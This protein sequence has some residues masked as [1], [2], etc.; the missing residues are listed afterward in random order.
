[1]VIEAEGWVVPGWSGPQAGDGE[2]EGG[3]QEPAEQPAYDLGPVSTPSRSAASPADTECQGAVTRRALDGGSSGHLDG[4]LTAALPA[5][6]ERD[7][8]DE[9]AEQ[10]D[11]RGGFVDQ[12]GEDESHQDRPAA[13]TA[14]VSMTTLAPVS[15]C[16]RSGRA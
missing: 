4:G 15:W 2:R 16:T 14:R 1:M 7:A 6:V 5:D 3:D 12:G 13:R 11:H 10:G 9:D 8:D